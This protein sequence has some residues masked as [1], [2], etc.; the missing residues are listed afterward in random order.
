[1]WS[2]EQRRG[3]LRLTD[4]GLI[5]L[6]F[7]LFGRGVG[8]VALFGRGCALCGRGIVRRTSPLAGR[9]LV[10]PLTGRSRIPPL[11]GGR[12]MTGTWTKAN[13]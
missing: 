9:R 4:V 6:G 10:S 11:G 1:M 7:A 2:G 8:F 12:A 3:I 13:T 5:T